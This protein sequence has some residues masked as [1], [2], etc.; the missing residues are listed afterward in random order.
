MC[1]G[2]CGRQACQRCSTLNGGCGEFY[3][4]V[5]GPDHQCGQ[6]QTVKDAGADDRAGSSV[7]N[8][9]ELVNPREAWKEERF[10]ELSKADFLAAWL[11]EDSRNV[12]IGRPGEWG[13]DCK[14][15]GGVSREEAVAKFRAK[16]RSSPTM[17]KKLLQLLHRRLGCW[18]V[19]KECLGGGDHC[20]VG[21][22][23][24]TGGAA[25]S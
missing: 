3:C 4:A 23:Q 22:T 20:P 16:L 19:P 7:A 13:N 14:S 24:R 15:G 25:V 5:C 6:A 11:K 9:T 10:R 12:Y 1:W 17:T 2:E 21:G 18:C 8:T